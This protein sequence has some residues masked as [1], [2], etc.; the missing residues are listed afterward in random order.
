MNMKTLISIIA[1]VS[2]SLGLVTA[3]DARDYGDRNHHHSSGWN[4]HRHHGSTG[5]AIR[6]Y[7]NFGNGGYYNDDYYRIR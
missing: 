4:H 3:A 2:L 6:F 1:G 5:T 7:G